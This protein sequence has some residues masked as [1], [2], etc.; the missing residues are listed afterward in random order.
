MIPP[1][2][3]QCQT[4][5]KEGSFMTL[6]PRRYVRCKNKPTVIATEKKPPEGETELGSMSLCDDCKKVFIE[7]MGEDYATFTPIEEKADGS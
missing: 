1:D 5:I 3:K 2:P 6:G 7:K 4:E